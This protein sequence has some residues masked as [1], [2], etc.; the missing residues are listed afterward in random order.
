[1]RLGG[2]LVLRDADRL[3]VPAV[4]DV[5]GHLELAPEDAGIV[6][7]VGEYA[8]ILDDAPGDVE[9]WAKIGPK[10]LTALEALGASPRARAALKKG[11]APNAVQNRLAVLREARRAN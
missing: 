3:L 7:L 5:L 10:L 1:V 9:V 6:R 11:G 8:R 2:G 4:S